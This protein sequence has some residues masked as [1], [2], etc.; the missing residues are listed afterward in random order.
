MAVKASGQI[1]LSTVVDVAGTYRYYLL[2]SS[3]AALPPKPTIFPP[4]TW[5]DVEPGY[6][7]GSTNSL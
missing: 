1:T 7:D 3:T 6:T 5:D 2:Q 4:S